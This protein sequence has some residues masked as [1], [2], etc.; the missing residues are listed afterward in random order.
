MIKARLFSVRNIVTPD[1]FHGVCLLLS[2]YFL[3]QSKNNYYLIKLGT[4]TGTVF[5]DLFS[6]NALL[7]AEERAQLEDEDSELLNTAVRLST[8]TLGGAGAQYPTAL[9]Q[10]YRNDIEW[11]V[12]L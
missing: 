2:T 6:A 11:R 5:E 12:M 3:V 8:S 1:Y 10:Y 9:E 7:T 4:Y